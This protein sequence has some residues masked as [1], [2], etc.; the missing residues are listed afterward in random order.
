MDKMQNLPMANVA[1]SPTA[2]SLRPLMRDV[3]ITESSGAL[4]EVN[5]SVRDLAIPEHSE[6]F[7]YSRLPHRDSIRLLRLL[8]GSRNDDLCC[9]IFLARVSESPSY[10]CISYV[11]GELFKV[12]TL[13]CNGKEVRITR[14]LS[15]VLR[16]L[17]NSSKPR[18]L[19]A[20]AICIN[21]NSLEERGQQV[22]LMGSIYKNASQVL[23]HLGDDLGQDA[24][25]LHDFVSSW[26]KLFEKHSFDAL[27]QE[28][29][30]LPLEVIEQ[31]ISQHGIG[32]W[33]RVWA[34]PWFRRVWT[35]QEV[36]VASGSVVLYGD[37]EFNWDFLMLL[38]SCFAYSGL[39]LLNQP[40]LSFNARRM[41]VSYD[42]HSR[43]AYSKSFGKVPTEAIF[44]YCLHQAASSRMASDPLDMIYAFLGHP[45]APTL[46]PA[47]YKGINEV[48][49][50]LAIGLF[51][52]RKS[53][54]L[55]SYASIDERQG[56]NENRP[57]WCP[58]WTTKPNRS[59][60]ALIFARHS[61]TEALFAV[62]GDPLKYP[63]N[64][65]I[66]N[67]ALR[68]T[69]V[70]F[71]VVKHAFGPI[72]KCH[73]FSDVEV[74]SEKEQNPIVDALLHVTS[75]AY[76][77]NSPYSELFRAISRTFSAEQ[78]RAD[79]V[80]SWQGIH[81]IPTW[82]QYLKRHHLDTTDATCT[83]STTLPLYTEEWST[84]RSFFITDTG[85]LGIGPPTIKP[86][87]ICAAIMGAQV[88]FILRPSGPGRHQLVGEAYIHGIMDGEI[89]ERMEGGEFELELLTLI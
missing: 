82:R 73:I 30:A 69:G 9:E 28:I 43:N 47:Y 14:N 53:P 44:L 70:K 27:S 85:R 52:V 46:E 56:I 15:S 86:A 4:F 5:N 66:E 42:P 78:W 40:C 61:L 31:I 87:D 6:D 68:T 63:F 22:H 75:E 83:E 34:Q 19:W 38:S 60:R 76:V 72:Q 32:P 71:D 12:V 3:S 10:E 2:A 37:Y 39:Y 16:R 23:I 36:G 25:P 24:Q 57:S 54:A 80:M 89:A 59:L 74:P 64:C 18:T 55:L 1:V 45:Y 29:S 65:D 81:S 26:M 20:D 17:R 41:W 67:L 77:K 62:S 49:M 50:E 7:K 79:E 21:Q 84:G 88:P 13:Y 48:C 51:S 35:V 33:R 11:W 8:P 58:I